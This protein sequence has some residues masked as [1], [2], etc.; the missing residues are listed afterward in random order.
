MSN[1]L[2]SDFVFLTAVCKKKNQKLS[3]I[4]TAASSALQFPLTKSQ[5]LHALDILRAGGYISFNGNTA[6]AELLIS[7]T[8]KG[9]NAT[10]TGF[11]AMLSS[12]ARAAELLKLEQAFCLNTETADSSDVSITD[13]EYVAINRRLYADYSVS[14]PFVEAFLR[15]G[16][17][18]FSF[19]SSG[20][21]YSPMG[22]GDS[23][24]TADDDD[25]IPKD[26]LDVVCNGEKYA[27]GLLAATADF[28]LVSSKVRKFALEDNGGVYLFSLS[29]VKDGA[30][31]TAAKILY[32]KQR[33]IGKRDSALDYAQ[34]GE[35]ILDITITPALLSSA[36]LR[37]YSSVPSIL[38]ENMLNMMTDL[39][40]AGV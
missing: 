17:L 11:F 34:C 4:F 30:R 19:R 12:R 31:L 37:A 10:R 40:A 14:V 33:F 2:Y 35:N 9:Y 22:S 36:V 20:C 26:S 8:E 23:E 18:A 7:A 13:D 16:M 1:Y 24:L 32:N 15:D 21:G 29:Y 25:E 38:T 6:V 5:L 27:D 28:L 3:D 39:R